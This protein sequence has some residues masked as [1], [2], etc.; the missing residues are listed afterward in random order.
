[1]TDTL[2][3][4]AP[5]TPGIPA[6][7]ES[8]RYGE[9]SWTD[10]HHIAVEATRSDE[11]NVGLV[12][13]FAANS[14]DWRFV[15]VSEGDPERGIARLDINSPDIEVLKRETVNV[16]A[17]YAHK[18]SFET[19]VV[20]WGRYRFPADQ[21]FHE[22]L[23]WLVG[24]EIQMMRRLNQIHQCRLITVDG[25]LVTLVDDVAREQTPVY[26]MS[27]ALSDRRNALRSITHKYTQYVR[28]ARSDTEIEA[29]ILEFQG[30]VDQAVAA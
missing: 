24:N 15:L 10:A 6:F 18:A 9:A 26:D 8:V 7:D 11:G 28:A 29:L 20:L 22:H 2:S 1:M 14:A 23:I 21:K 4:E 30:A 5:A 27:I 3:P 25:E 12:E 13:T 19:P 16:F 17:K